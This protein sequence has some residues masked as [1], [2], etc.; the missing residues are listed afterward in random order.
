VLA[1]FVVGYLDRF[2]A[3]N[4][5]DGEVKVG[6]VTIVVILATLVIRPFGL[7]GKAGTH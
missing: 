7:L 2:V 6:L 4:V 3:Y 5:P 1:A